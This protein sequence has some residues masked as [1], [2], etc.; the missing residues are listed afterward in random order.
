VDKA[1]IFINIEVRSL[2][3]SSAMGLREQ[4]HELITIKYFNIYVKI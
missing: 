3:K 1:H 2:E 4:A